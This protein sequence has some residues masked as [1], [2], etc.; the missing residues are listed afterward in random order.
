[1]ARK[2]MDPRLGMIPHSADPDTGAVQMEP[3]G[4][5][6]G[7]VTRMLYEIDTEFAADQ[8][9]KAREHFVVSHL[10]LFPGFYEYAKDRSGPGDVDSGPLVF[11]ISA[12]ASVLGI[13]AAKFQG[14]REF[15]D[16]TLAGVHAV[17]M[18]LFDRYGAGVLP[19]GEA[20]LAWTTYAH[21]WVGPPPE[22]AEWDA[23]MLPGWRFIWHLLSALLLAGLF[24][25][26]ACCHRQATTKRKLRSY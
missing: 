14:D 4:C 1:M 26:R 20:F 12:S 24:Q 9:R 23:I 18:P 7:V 19:V 17:G 11:G 15:A 25:R 8:Y 5:S 10:G 21:P 22:P 6:N 16:P 3:R 2:R 13:A